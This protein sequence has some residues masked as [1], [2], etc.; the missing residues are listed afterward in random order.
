MKGV[1]LPVAGMVLLACGSARADSK[2]VN[3]T[4]RILVDAPPPC[5]VKA[6]RW[7]LAMS[8]LKHRRQQLSAACWLHP[9]LFEQRQR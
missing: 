8:L 3:L 1:L 9:E 5:T 6:A 4:L 7:S 2:T